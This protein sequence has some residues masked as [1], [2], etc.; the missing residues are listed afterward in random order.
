MNRLSLRC[1]DINYVGRQFRVLEGIYWPERQVQ[2]GIFVTQWTV[3]VN[4]HDFRTEERPENSSEGGGRHYGIDKIPVRPG[5]PRRVIIFSKSLED[6]LE[7][8][9]TVI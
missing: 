5:I 8:V 6:H 1:V 3:P 7:Q 4:T 2:D 9:S